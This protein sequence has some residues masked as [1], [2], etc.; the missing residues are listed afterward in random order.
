M[1]SAWW[2]LEK[3]VHTVLYPAGDIC[4]AQQRVLCG[5]PAPQLA[6]HIS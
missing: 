6:M 5:C 3:N 2:V 1:C 4:W